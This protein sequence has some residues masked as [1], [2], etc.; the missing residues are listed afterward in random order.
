MG[1]IVKHVVNV[2]ENMLDDL[3]VVL[4]RTFNQNWTE[5]SKCLLTENNIMVAPDT[6]LAGYPAIF[7]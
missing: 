2:L 4:N 7:C 5:Y 3:V 6:E 1:Q